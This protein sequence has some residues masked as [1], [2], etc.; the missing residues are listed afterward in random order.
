MVFNSGCN[1]GAVTVAERQQRT[2]IAADASG[3]ADRLI[4]ERRR[5][6]SHWQHERWCQKKL[7]C[8]VQPA[9]FPH[10]SLLS[11]PR[12]QASLQPFEN[13][14]RHPHSFCSISVSITT[15]LP[16]NCYLCLFSFF[17]CVCTSARL[18][19]MLRL[20]LA[21]PA[22][23]LPLERGCAAS[24]HA[25]HEEPPLHTASEVHD[26]IQLPGHQ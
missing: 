10:L 15:P 23:Q 24:P 19:G 20:R 2:P 17:C 22:G 12:N 14:L 9:R 21:R 26:N 6:R 3:G 18:H 8:L 1:A 13:Q 7:R 16:V 5:P 4:Q 11:K 25:L